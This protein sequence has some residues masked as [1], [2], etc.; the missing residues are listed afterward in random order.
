MKK[1]ILSLILLGMMQLVFGQEVLYYCSRPLPSGSWQVYKKNLTSGTI[2]T[3]TSNTA[4]NYWWV[5]L[6]PDRTQLLMLRSPYSS[7][8]DQ[9]DY[10]NCEM[11]K[12]NADGSN[13]RIILADDQY[14]WYAFGNPHWHLNGK[15]IL[16]I[17]QPTNSAAP[18]YVVTIDTSGNNP[19]LLIPQWSIDANWSPTGDKIVFVGIDAGGFVNATSF[20]V[21]IANY[22]YAANTVSGIKQLTT[23]ATRD[24][25]PCFSKDGLK[26]AFSASDANITNAD[27][28]TIDTTGANR[29]AVLDDAGVHGGPVNWGTDGKIYH[30]SIYIGST[31]FT[32]NAFNTNTSGYETFFASP[33]YGY[34]SPYYANL[35]TVGIN[36]S[37]IEKSGVSIFPNP[38]SI[39]TKFF[40]NVSLKDATLTLYNVYGQ[41]VKHLENISG[42]TI[43]LNRDNL[44]DGVYFIRIIEDNKII[45]ASKLVITD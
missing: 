26:I 24:H 2:A 9:F 15:R 25:D 32:V 36:S 22:N 11:I 41:A 10:V 44:L 4:Y 3:I 29:T 18:F 19:S 30:H 14:N 38:F 40:T 23:D 17:A 16:M 43:T 6:S 1:I 42:Q 8:T 13:Q 35:N 37:F 39:E 31:D 12:S 21:F 7:P 20:E 28:V 33:S 45:T 27:I 34:L 5:E